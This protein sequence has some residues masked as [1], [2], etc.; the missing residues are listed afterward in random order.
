[1]Q[2][3]L[4]EIIHKNN[5]KS[6]NV[7]NEVNVTFKRIVCKPQTP[8]KH[9]VFKLRKIFDFAKTPTLLS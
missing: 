5:K 4:S 9:V 1:M 3:R 2:K 6:L 7:T 8:R